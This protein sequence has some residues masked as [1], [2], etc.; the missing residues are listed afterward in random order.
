MRNLR[1][2]LSDVLRAECTGQDLV[3]SEDGRLII[4]GL[5]VDGTLY[6]IGCI[7]Y[8]AIL[9]QSRESTRRLINYIKYKTT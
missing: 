6:E 8:D 1:E 7:S 4:C 3:E 2:R 5:S 9:S